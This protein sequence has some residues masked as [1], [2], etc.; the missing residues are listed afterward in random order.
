MHRR[1]PPRSARSGRIRLGLLLL[2]TL[3]LVVFLVEGVLRAIQF[4]GIETEQLK[5]SFV[6]VQE[7]S[8][9]MGHPYLAYAP[10]PLS[11]IHI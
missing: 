11:L 8:R 1:L 6:A 4:K 9:S 2:L 5:P 10:K 3:L 7:T